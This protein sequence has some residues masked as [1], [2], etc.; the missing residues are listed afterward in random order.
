[1]A[2]ALGTVAVDRMRSATASTEEEIH[3]FMEAAFS[4]DD[5][6]EDTVSKESN[7]SGNK[8]G[9][10]DPCMLIFQARDAQQKRENDWIPCN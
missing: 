7:Q 9:E 5:K 4:D 1:M 2:R 3:G 10:R 6:D 8:E